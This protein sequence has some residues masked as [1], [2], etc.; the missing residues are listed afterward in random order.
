M[1]SFPGG[2]AESEALVDNHISQVVG[3]FKGRFGYWIVV[4]ECLDIQ[5]NGRGGLKNVPIYNALGPAALDIAFRTAHAADPDAELTL[6]EVDLEMPFPNNERKRANMLRLIE[7]MKARDVPNHALGLESHLRS[8]YGFNAAQVRRFLAEVAGLGLKIRVTELDVDD[9]GYVTDFKARDVACARLVKDYLDVV[10]ANTSVDMVVTWGLIDQYSWLNLPS[11]P[12]PR[13]DQYDM[14]N[15]R[16]D[17]T[18]HRPLPYGDDLQP[19]PIRQAIAD[20]LTGA[21]NR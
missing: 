13:M 21:P 15:F 5:G 11:Q 1:R 10:L 7:G 3:H 14:R 4:N 12:V 16:R 2:R 6:N 9:R 17:G 18:K 20:A 8:Q 19:K